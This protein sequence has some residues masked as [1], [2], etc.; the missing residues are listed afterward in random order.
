MVNGPSFVFHADL[1]QS[2]RTA[3]YGAASDK[4][5]PSLR[6][7]RGWAYTSRGGVR[8]GGLAALVPNWGG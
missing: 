6:P 3:P 2:Q 4:D 7:S 5:L 8:G 1:V